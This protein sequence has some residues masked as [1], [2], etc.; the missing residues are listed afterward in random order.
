MTVA[1]G[2]KTSLWQA[3]PPASRSHP[4]A[5]LQ[6]A[7]A[8]RRWH[9]GQVHGLLR[10]WDRC[11]DDS[12]AEALPLAMQTLEEATRCLVG[13]VERMQLA[14][15]TDAY[16]HPAVT[17]VDE[18]LDGVRRCLEATAEH[19][20]R[21][22]AIQLELAVHVDALA[23]DPGSWPRVTPELDARVRSVL[24]DRLSLLLLRETRSA[25]RILR[26]RWQVAATQSD[27]R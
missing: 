14:P 1:E 24:Q 7:A 5:R 4:N 6:A 26:A 9:L 19:A 17:R 27:T 21:L 15:G 10:T 3:Q 20:E 11:A 25:R 13:G 8:A 23:D 22:A 18:A 16:A 2:M 12:L